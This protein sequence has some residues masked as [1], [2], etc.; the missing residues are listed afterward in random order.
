MSQNEKSTTFIVDGMKCSG[1]SN[2]IQN[3]LSI[4]PEILSCKVDLESKKVEIFYKDLLDV[5]K[6]SKKI[7]D[8]G[9]SVLEII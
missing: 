9:F 2:R 5:R 4:I 8:L 6:V 7:E 1:C 3:A